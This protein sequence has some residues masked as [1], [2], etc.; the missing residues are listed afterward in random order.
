MEHVPRNASL[1]ALDLVF[2]PGLLAQTAGA[3]L[4]EWLAANVAGREQCAGLLQG[5]A[6]TGGGETYLSYLWKDLKVFDLR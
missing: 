5:C 3:P 2:L 4:D 6:R 1:Q